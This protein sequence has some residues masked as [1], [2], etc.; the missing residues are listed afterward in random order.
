MV[1][2]KDSENWGRLLEFCDPDGTLHTWAMPMEMLK[3]NGEELRGT[4]L[5]S[6]LEIAPGTQTKNRLIE[7]IITNKPEIRVRCITQT[8]WF[9]QSFVLPNRT[10]GETIEKVIYQ[11]ENHTQDYKQSGTL[12]DWQQNIARY[13][14]GNSRLVLSISSAFAALLLYP[15][16]SESGGLHLV[17]ESSTGKTTALKV[18]ASVF[19][20]PDYLH[21]WR[22]TMNGIEA[23][24]AL[25]SDTLLILDELSQVDPK[26]AGEIAAPWVLNFFP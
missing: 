5:R 6:G 20:A 25:H 11:S 18:A 14:E 9:N 22:A 16:G 21:R 17:G 8:G 7:Y 26:E 15:T 13:C 10:I 19:G 3:G 4:L 23:L 1:R 2:D 24:A 12:E